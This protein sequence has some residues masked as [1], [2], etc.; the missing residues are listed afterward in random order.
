MIAYKEEIMP[1]AEP[2]LYNAGSKKGC[3]MIHGFTGSPYNMKVIGKYLYENGITAMGVRLAGHGTK[4]R[5]M[6][7]CS[8]QDWIASAEEGFHELKKI[9]DEVYVAGLSMGG[10]L[11]LHLATEFGADIAGIIVMCAPVQVKGWRSKLIPLAPVISKLIPYI[12]NIGGSTKDKSVEEVNYKWF[13][14][15]SVQELIKLIQE[16]TGKVHS[17]NQ[18]AV[19]IYSEQDPLVTENSADFI[20]NNIASE[21]KKLMIVKNSY[22]VITLDYDKAIVAREIEAFING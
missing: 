1:G 7:K 16:V 17:I 5:D 11:T 8:Y 6:A 19:L 15:I 22:H 9:C 3:L 20:F 14:S 13:P 4:P 10:V 2:F 12:P 18:P 21:D